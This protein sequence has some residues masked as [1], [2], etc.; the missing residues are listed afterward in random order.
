MFSMVK[1]VF[2]GWIGMCVLVMAMRMALVA[3]RRPPFP[4]RIRVPFEF[5]HAMLA[6]IGGGWICARFGREETLLSAALLAAW[7]SGLEFVSLRAGWTSYEWAH[8]TSM[9]LIAPISVI[10]SA[11]MLSW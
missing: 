7:C 8:A 11:L 5:V 4:D 6:G 2:Q 1:I 10:A 9:I 3:L